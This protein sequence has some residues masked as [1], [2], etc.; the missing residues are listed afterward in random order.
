ML[1]REIP[2]KFLVAFSLSSVDIE[3]VR[4]IAEAVEAKLGRGTVFFYE[5]F[6][7]H[8]AG[9]DGDLKLQEIYGA[10]SAVTVACLSEAYG[11]RPWT[12]SEHECIR[13]R[14]IKARSSGN[15]SDSYGV[16]PIR[17]GD[18]DVQGL[19]FTTFA[20]DVRLMP[21][22]SAAQLVLDRL[23][24][25]APGTAFGTPPA[26]A[27]APWPAT[28]PALDWPIADHG[29][30]REAFASMLRH[31]STWSYL[32]LRGASESGKSHLTQLML[33][34]LQTMPEIA[35]GRFDFKGT[36]DVETELLAFVQFLGVARPVGSGPLQL[37]QTLTAIL[38]DLK[39]RAAPT[40]LL[41]DTYEVAGD[42]QNWVERVLLPHVPRCDWLR[43]AIAG[44]SVPHVAA[45]A[46]S[47][48]SHPILE[49]V[50]P[51]PE[52]WWEFGSRHKPDLDIDFV[53]SA[54][55]YCRGK[56][57]VLAQL[58]GPS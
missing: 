5:W 30:V 4:R 34:N 29:E 58:L 3:L 7:H 19:Q 55:G 12:L 45:T 40:F 20:P 51:S 43:V 2:E 37:N 54:H 39:R 16:L 22:E 36:A 14:T 21:L 49:V 50:R 57:S 17:V 52:D 24:L 25:A 6:Q 26:S 27:E 44:Q 41:F 56:P 31:S 15:P 38:E 28:I 35:C 33:A 48:R 46:W 9:A 47:A 18:G 11:K 13:S 10:R 53:R 1:P 23:Q 32:P 42:A 8:L